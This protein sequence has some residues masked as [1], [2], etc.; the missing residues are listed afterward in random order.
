MG[1]LIN[2]L[3]TY[4]HDSAE[5]QEILDSNE[6]EI[7]SLLADSKPIFIDNLIL[8]AS[9]ERISGWERALQLTPL[10][11]LEERRVYV[12]SVLMGIGKLNEK[13]II[14]IVDI[15]TGGGGAIVTF[16]NGVIDVKV[17][18][19]RN[20]EGFDFASIERSINKQRPA[21]LGLNVVRYYSTWGDIKEQ[22]TSWQ[23]VRDSKPS[24]RDVY[25]HI[26][27]E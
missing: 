15:F 7:D 8:Q 12:L 19:P 16:A 25:N 6:V 24:W 21:H 13:K 5:M 17:L 27:R 4:W 23:D 10:G 1:K 2:Y 14:D 9:E 22:F 11:T 3:P 20:G 26:V 18:P